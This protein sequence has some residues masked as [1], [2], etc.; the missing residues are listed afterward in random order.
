MQQFSGAPGS[1]AILRGKKQ[2]PQGKPDTRKP[3]RSRRSRVQRHTRRSSSLA[4]T[5]S[6]DEYRFTPFQ[7]TELI[8]QVDA[9]IRG[10]ANAARV[11]GTSATADNYRFGDITVDFSRAKVNKAGEAVDLSPQELKL[12]RCFV[13]R[14]D[15]ILTRDEVLHAAWGYTTPSTRTVDVHVGQLRQKLEDNPRRPRF[16]RTVHGRGYRFDAEDLTVTNPIRDT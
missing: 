1:R 4:A 3:A 15:S 7:L 13:E 9:L 14:R 6:V 12:L 11:S 10:A 16:I 8:A 5:E 2:E